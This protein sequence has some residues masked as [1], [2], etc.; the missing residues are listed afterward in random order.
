MAIILKVRDYMQH[1]VKTAGHMLLKQCNSILNCG[2]QINQTVIRYC[3][4]CGEKLTF[5]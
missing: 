2:K 1:F 5:K 4:N 3:P